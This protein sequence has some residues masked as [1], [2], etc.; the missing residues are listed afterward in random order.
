MTKIKTSE[1]KDEKLAYWAARAQGWEL[2][3]EF[4]GYMIPDSWC[5]K[6][7]YG[8]LAVEVIHSKEDYRPDI[9]G[10]QA[11]EL[12]EKFG[13]RIES[14][15]RFWFGISSEEFMARGEKKVWIC[16]A[17]VASVHGEYVDDK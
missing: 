6:S 17:V 5:I 14:M 9:N 16:R 13:E 10:G 7:K 8:F 4:D 11:M 12:L 2:H 15:L 3:G 1:L